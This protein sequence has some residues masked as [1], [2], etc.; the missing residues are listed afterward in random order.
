MNRTSIV[1]HITSAAAVAAACLRKLY[2][3][4]KFM[5]GL[6]GLLGQLS[7][8]QVMRFVADKTQECKLVMWEKTMMPESVM[9]EVD[10]KKKFVKTGVMTEMTTYTFRDGFGDILKILTKENGYRSLEGGQ[11]VITL[12]VAWNDFQNR[13]NV[14]LVSVEK[15][16]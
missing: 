6:G 5:I 1:P 9:Q 14:R 4:D 10:G 2:A 3:H 15:A 13:N 12:E 7:Y 16:K 8:T 11:V